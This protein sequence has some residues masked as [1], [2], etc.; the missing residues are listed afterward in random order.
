ME[1]KTDH[2]EQRV[3]ALEEQVASLTTAVENLQSN[4]TA[5]LSTSDT[6][7]KSTAIKTPREG[8]SEE[9]LS[10]VDKSAI[11][12]RV[13]TT[14]FVL[15]VA[16]ALRTAADS[17]TLDLQLGSFI[18][19]LFA[20]GLLV[21]GWFAYRSKSI[22]APVFILWGTIVMCAVV[23]EA[24]RVFSTI[25]AE[26]A[27]FAMSMTGGV[28]TIISRRFRVALPVFAGTIG[29]SFGAF[30][31]DYPSPVFPYLAVIMIFANI[32]A[33]Y[34]PHICSAPHG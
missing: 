8:T 10:W 24:H 27:Y 11:L 7:V 4:M 34:M 5:S 9:I 15:A 21:S 6:A 14:S 25:P 17:G 3:A 13:A 23:V 22:H 12:P 1:P 26:A 29:M 20:F 31:L 30:A 19:M 16:L 2:L 32:F 33:A 18:G 28:T